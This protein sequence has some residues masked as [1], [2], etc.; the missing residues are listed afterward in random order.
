MVVAPD[1]DGSVS[2]QVFVGWQHC[3]ED[4][5][6]DG[7]DHDQANEAAQPETPVPGQVKLTPEAIKQA[8]IETAPVVSGSLDNR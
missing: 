3:H 1:H 8:G 7:H 4:H 2:G 5:D 6:H